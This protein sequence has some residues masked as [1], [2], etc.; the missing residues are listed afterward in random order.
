MSTETERILVSVLQRFDK[1]GDKEI[2]WAEFS[3]ALQQ[4]QVDEPTLLVIRD[5]VFANWDTNSDQKLSVAEIDA[6]VAKWAS[7]PG[8]QS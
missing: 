7:F 6:M 4:E 2:G 8:D 3:E 5:Q 1:N